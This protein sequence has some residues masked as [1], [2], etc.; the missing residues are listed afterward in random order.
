ME[1]LAKIVKK[2]HLKPLPILT[3]RSTLDTLLDPNCASADGYQIVVKIQ[4]EICLPD[5]KYKDGIILISSD[6]LNI[7]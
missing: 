2:V 7:N 3:K 6:C 4:T 1:L 5:S